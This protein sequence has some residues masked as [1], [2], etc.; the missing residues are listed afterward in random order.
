MDFKGQGLPLDDGGMDRICETLGVSDAE[1]WAVL[2]VETR[3]FGFLSDRS[4]A[5]LFERHWF[6]KLTENKH[7]NGNSDISNRLPGGYLGGKAEYSRLEKALALDEEAALKSASWGIGQVM[8]FNFRVA[9]YSSVKEMVLAMI[10]AENEQLLGMANF[11]KGNGLAKALQR[12]NWASFAKG[13]NGRDF[14]KNEY[15]TRLAAAHAKY[16]KILPDLG[17]R[18]AQAALMFLGFNPGPID[19]LRGRRTRSALTDFQQRF[20]LN[21]S[22][23]LDADTEDKLMAEAFPS[24]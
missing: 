24:E 6:H 2:T 3:G 12:Q 11:I 23:E 1:I 18:Q 13:Y 5:I 15:D 21:A 7:D 19:G 20:G 17:L 22:G 10:Q 16:C 9:G 8:G 4:P 14:K